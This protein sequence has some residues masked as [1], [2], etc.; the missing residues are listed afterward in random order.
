VFDAVL[1][2]DRFHVVKR[3]N[4]A[5]DEVRKEQWRNGSKEGRKFYKDIR[6]ILFR[7]SSIRS[8]KDTETLKSL[9]P[10]CKRA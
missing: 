7:H 9:C 6:W 3:L 4:A 8:P 2:L 1:V 5:V 10:F